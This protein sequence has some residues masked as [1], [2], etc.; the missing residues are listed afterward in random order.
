MRSEIG[1]E[2]K[3]SGSEFVNVP[4]IYFCEDTLINLA[5]FDHV[6]NL[7]GRSHSGFDWKE[8]PLSCVIVVSLPSFVVAENF[9]NVLQYLYGLMPSQMDMFMTE[10]NPARRHS[11]K[12][13]EVIN[14]V[15]INL[16]SF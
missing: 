7:L 4:A 6:V 14:L 8:A 9:K 10:D 1:D 11:E 12:V 16:V 2:F 15:S 5:P 3:S 13:T